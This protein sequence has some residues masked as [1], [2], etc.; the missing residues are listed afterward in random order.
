MKYF[1]YKKQMDKGI[2][3]LWNTPGNRK[4]RNCFLFILIF[5]TGCS[6]KI[7]SLSGTSDP[8][9]SRESVI[10]CPSVFGLTAPQADLAF[11]MPRLDHNRT[12]RDAPC[13]GD[14]AAVLASDPFGSEIR[15]FR[16]LIAKGYR[17][18]VN[19]PSSILLDGMIRQSMTTIPASPEFEYAYLVRAQAAGLETMAFFRSLEQA[20][21]ALKAG[22]TQLV[23]H[24]GVLDIEDASAGKMLLG[25]LERLVETLKGDGSNPTI[26][27]YTSDW[28]E[29]ILGLSSLPVDGLVQLKAKP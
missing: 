29:R 1:I 14:W 20:R 22:L 19:W 21:A 4:I 6:M 18:V 11:L 23:L 10:F 9:A 26:L 2:S 15:A 28:H 25:S 8:D 27:V 5:A 24:P 3:H 13:R 7:Y 16:Q 17:G 12:L